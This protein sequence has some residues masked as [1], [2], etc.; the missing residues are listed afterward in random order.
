MRFRDQKIRGVPKFK[1]GTSKKRRNAAKG[2]DVL[3]KDNY[4]LWCNP[5]DVEKK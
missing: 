3:T 5:W 2:V 4:V 1:K